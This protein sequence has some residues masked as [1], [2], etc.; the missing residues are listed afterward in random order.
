[1]L[2]WVFLCVTGQ[3]SWLT[4]GQ[5]SMNL[6]HSLFEILQN[7]IMVLQFEFVDLES[8]LIVFSCLI[9]LIHDFTEHIFNRRLLIWSSKILL[10]QVLIL[11]LKLVIVSPR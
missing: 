6:S 3:F 11:M 4:L 5:H 9:N 7:R 2:A 10:L 8:F 1:M